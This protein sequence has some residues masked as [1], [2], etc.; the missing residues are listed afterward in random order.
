[1]LITISWPWTALRFGRVLGGTDQRPHLRQRHS[2][3]PLALAA[4]WHSEFQW[5]QGIDG[6]LGWG[7]RG[8]AAA[9]YVYVELEAHTYSYYTI[10][11]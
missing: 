9:A 6:A 11:Y 7:E 8:R 4:L 1:M 10:M 5:P 2:L 3:S